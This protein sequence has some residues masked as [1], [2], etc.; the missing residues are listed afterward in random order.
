MGSD[1]GTFSDVRGIEARRK[2]PGRRAGL[3]AL[4]TGVLAALVATGVALSS[5]GRAPAEQA[6]PLSPIVAELGAAIAARAPSA[7]PPPVEA[8]PSA[9]VDPPP[10]PAPQPRPPSRAAAPRPQARADCRVPYVLDAE[11]NKRY[12]PQC[13]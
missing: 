5:S 2:R 13:L 9:S 11:G 10:K 3:A 1:D 8:E 6:A 4:S 12:K 7:A